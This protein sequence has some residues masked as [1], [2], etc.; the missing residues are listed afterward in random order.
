[1]FSFKLSSLSLKSKFGRHQSGSTQFLISSPLSTTSTTTRNDD[2]NDNQ[3]LPEWFQEEFSRIQAERFL[4]DKEIGVFVVRKSETHANSYVLSV[5]V[6]KYLNQREVSH[7]LVINNP[8]NQ[9]F[10]VKGFEKEFPDLKSLV[11]HCSLMRDFLP[12]ML[13]VDYYKRESSSRRQEDNNCVR[14]SELVY[15]FFSSPSRS[16]SSLSSVLSSQ[17]SECG[18]I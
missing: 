17:S 11:T 4:M 14:E 7:Y 6:P 1:M 2:D 12:I 18:S 10:S 9:C 5:R 16:T 15:C 13:N 3:E 8:T